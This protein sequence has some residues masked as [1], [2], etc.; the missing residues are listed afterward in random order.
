MRYGRAEGADVAEALGCRVTSPPRTAW[1]L[2]RRL[3][4]VE[5][6]VAV[7]AL[8]HGATFAP[9]ELLVRRG[10]RRC[11][12]VDRIVALADPRAESPMEPG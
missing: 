9:A 8:A 3:S 1:D 10:A 4:L 11:R 2:A 7:D 6:V 12:R 5:A